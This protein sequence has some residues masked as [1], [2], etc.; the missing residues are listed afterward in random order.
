[1]RDVSIGDVA[2]TWVLCARPDGEGFDA[3]YWEPDLVVSP[4]KLNASAS[5]KAGE[6]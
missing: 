5:L 6:E 1:M 4:F 3:V 2:A